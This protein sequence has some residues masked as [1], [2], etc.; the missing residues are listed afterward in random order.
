MTLTNL[1]PVRVELFYR[2][3]IQWGFERD[4]GRYSYKEINDSL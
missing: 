4:S 3:W 1:S 2:T